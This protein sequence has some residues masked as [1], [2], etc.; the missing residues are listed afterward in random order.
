MKTRKY[1]EICKP[2]VDSNAFEVEVLPGKK[3]QVIC[4]REIDFSEIPS[5][6]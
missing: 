3:I 4:F 6:S 2:Q 5:Y 1:M